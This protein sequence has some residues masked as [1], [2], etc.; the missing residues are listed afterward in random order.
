MLERQQIITEETCSGHILFFYPSPGSALAA[1]IL[2]STWLRTGI[3]AQ[4]FVIIE[5]ET[6]AK[7]VM[8]RS[9][10]RAT[11]VDPRNLARWSSD[12]PGK[13][14]RKKILSREPTSD[15]IF[16]GIPAHGSQD[17]GLKAPSDYIKAGQPQGAPKHAHQRQCRAHQG[18]SESRG[19]FLLSKWWNNGA[20]QATMKT[21]GRLPPIPWL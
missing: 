2:L 11:M 4:R 21:V 1:S 20:V 10:E 9:A 6:D 13:F 14:V 12:M 18:A 8:Y 5:G 17:S 15:E 7:A 19:F 3:R 16:R